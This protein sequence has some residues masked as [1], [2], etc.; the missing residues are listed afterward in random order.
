M[1]KT[2]LSGLY[3]ITDAG[4]MPDDQQLL[5]SVAAAL[6]GGARIVQ[7]R[8][9]SDD[10]SKRLR[11]AQ[12]LAQLCRAHLAPL[13][14]NDDVE[15]ALASGADGVHLGQTDGSL[16]AARERL[17]AKAIIGITCH[18]QLDLALA[19]EQGGADYVA[20]GA[21]FPSSTKP[22]AIPAPLSLLQDARSRLHCP[23]VAIG[24]LSM[25]NASQVIQAGA[26]M[27]AVIHALF[28]QDDIEARARAF[29]QLFSA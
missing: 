5:D 11:Q 10:A 14:I 15:L 16:A 27:I 4:L 24:G 20:F 25:D 1:I 26:D 18:D 19:A 6:R 23:I 12:A 28:A 9:K 2:T 22:D 17:G 3:A 21:F 13:L 29:G 8:D 7:Y